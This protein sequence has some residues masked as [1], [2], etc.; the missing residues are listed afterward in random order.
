ASRVT[1]FLSKGHAASEGTSSRVDREK[2]LG[3]GLCESLCPFHAIKMGDEGIAEVIA[4]TCKGCGV[5]AASCP[6]KAIET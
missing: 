3:C 2:C 5:C 4:A 1:T 6:A